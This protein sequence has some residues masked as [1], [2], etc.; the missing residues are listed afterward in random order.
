MK[1]EKVEEKKVAVISIPYTPA[2]I[3]APARPKPLIITL[4]DPILYSR[5]SVNLGIM[6]Q[7]FITMELS[8]NGGDPKINQMKTQV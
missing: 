6:G 4:P 5:E 3:P 1:D 8:K 7:M 2:N